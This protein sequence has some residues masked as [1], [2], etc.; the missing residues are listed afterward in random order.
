MTKR[1]ALVIAAALAVGACATAPRGPSVMV[2]PGAGK[3]LDVFQ[4]DDGACRQWAS[5][6]VAADSDSAWM[7]QRR[8][9]IAYQQC[10]YSRGHQIP[11]AAAGGEPGPPRPPAAGP[12]PAP[13]QRVPTPPPGAA[14]PPP[15]APPPPSV[16]R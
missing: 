4:G 16:P 8:Y 14:T 11:G 13:G 12:Q 9:D 3:P 5:Q 15:D 7:V 6:Q 1:I 2:L 10:M